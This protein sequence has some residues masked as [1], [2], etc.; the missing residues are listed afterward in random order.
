VHAKNSFRALATASFDP[1]ISF[2][3]IG[4]ARAPIRYVGFFTDRREKQC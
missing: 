3:P 1:S 4:Y 2:F